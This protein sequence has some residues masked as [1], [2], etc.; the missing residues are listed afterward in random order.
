LIPHIGGMCLPTASCC[1]AGTAAITLPAVTADA[2]KEN[3]TLDH[4]MTAGE[5]CFS[6]QS[7]SLR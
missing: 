1:A 7:I 6:L 2:D 3:R 5:A 4:G